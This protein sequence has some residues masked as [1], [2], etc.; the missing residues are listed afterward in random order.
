MP[1][2][3]PCRLE[4]RQAVFPEHLLHPGSVRQAVQRRLSATQVAGR[5]YPRFI[6]TAPGA[7]GSL[8]NLSS[9]HSH[10]ATSQPDPAPVGPAVPSPPLRRLLSVIREAGAKPRWRLS[11]A[12][13][14]AVA[15]CSPSDRIRTPVLGEA[16]RGR[17]YPPLA[18]SLARAALK[19]SCRPALV[20]SGA[21]GASPPGF[22]GLPR[23]L[24]PPCPGPTAP[25]GLRG[26]AGR[27]GSGGRWTHTSARPSPPPGSEFKPVS[28]PTREPFRSLQV[29]SGGAGFPAGGETGRR[30][31]GEG[32]G[33]LA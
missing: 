15:F 23:G 24:R 8:M 27:G 5:C 11:L 20:L 17:S 12:Q 31:P 6:S 3:W 19:T 4:V 22:R 9:P 29:L 30:M 16:R 28:S 21:S 2:L 14:H 33:R 26:T 7:Q 18:F 13:A 1:G 10:P 25:C 32:E